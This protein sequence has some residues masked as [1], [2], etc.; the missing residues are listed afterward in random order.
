[1]MSL[2]R[3]IASVPF[4]LALTAL[5]LPKSSAFAPSPSSQQQQRHHLQQKQ[6]NRQQQTPWL[7]CFG[8]VF[9]NVKTSRTMLQSSALV[10]APDKESNFWIPM[11]KVKFSLIKLG[12]GGKQKTVNL[13]GLWVLTVSM[14]TMPFWILA[15][16]LEQLYMKINKKWDENRA[17]FDKTGKLWAKM[18]LKLIGSYPTQSG[19]L[20]MLKGKGIGPC[21]YVANHASWLDIPIVC[22]VL[23][24]VFKFIAKG[25]LR[26]APGIGQQLSGGKH[27]LIDREDKRSQ[28]KTFKLCIGWLKKGVPL[29]AFPEGTRS[30]TGRLLKFKGGAF[31]MARKTGVPIVPLTISH[32]YSI[33]PA[34][35]LLPI[36]RGGKKLH[37][38]VHD[39]IESKGRTEE[40]LVKMVRDAFCST[41][42]ECQLPAQTKTAQEEEASQ[43]LSDDPRP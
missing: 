8:H 22:T 5:S 4:L 25:D 43:E 17:I 37:V 15:L 31:A 3:I 41:L 21:L 35:G 19:N 33:W 2:G 27:I 32:S 36:Q 11:E 23:N 18:W 30:K 13:Q 29:M 7:D 9:H 26:N 1:M 10:A 14:L 20:E 34:Y 12:K 6:E 24:P 42:P 39:P 38:H 28:L 40:E 16:S